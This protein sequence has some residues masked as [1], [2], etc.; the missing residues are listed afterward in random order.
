MSSHW[1]WDGKFRKRWACLHPW[2]IA[3]SS[4]LRRQ[5]HTEGARKPPSD[6]A[7]HPGIRRGE[8]QEQPALAQETGREAA[9]AGTAH[10]TK[11]VLLTKHK[12]RRPRV[13]ASEP[14]TL[15]FQLCLW[16]LA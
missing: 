2:G 14:S 9:A 15:E 6:S 8:E 11:A 4:P 5:D 13:W 3:H 1:S 16:F 7:H 10:A 12:A